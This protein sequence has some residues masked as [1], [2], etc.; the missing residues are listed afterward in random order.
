MKKH[1]LRR[2]GIVAAA[3]ILSA[4]TLAM[5]AGCTTRHPEVTIVYSFDGTDYEV[6]YILSRNDAP[7]T[8]QHF[9]ELA[10]AKFYDGLCIHDYTSSYLYTGGYRL[11]DE[12]GNGWVADSGKSYELEEV[13]YF[14]WAENYEAEHGKTFTQTVWKNAG[15]AANPQKGQELYT[16]YGEMQSKVN[17]GDGSREYRH[18]QGA[19]VMYYTEKDVS[20]GYNV[21]VER[22]DGGKGNDGEKLQDEEYLYDS[23][24]SLFY[25]YT[26]PDTS[27]TRSDYCVFGK[28]KNY[29]D[30]L[31]NGLLKAIRDYIS[32]HSDDEDPEDEGGYSF[33]TQQEWRLNRYEKYFSGITADSNTA[34]YSLPLTE[35]IIIKSVRVK[36]Y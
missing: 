26:S 10:D 7:R 14:T 29:T 4:G 34:T 36:K 28:A 2:V 22:M 23:A 17:H 1:L 27:Y 11:V 35:P 21:V 16:V 13:D 5:F 33:T 19:L 31:E 9:I 3:A 12:E 15:T 8:V 6:D 25:T 30:Q 18:S 24:T 20:M 32:D